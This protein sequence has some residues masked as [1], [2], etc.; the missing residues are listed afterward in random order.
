MLAVIRLCTF[1]LVS[2]ELVRHCYCFDLIKTLASF[3]K[4]HDNKEQI[5]DAPSNHRV[6][7]SNSKC[8]VCHKGRV[9]LK[10]SCNAL[11]AHLA[12][13]D[14]QGTCEDSE[15][16]DPCDPSPCGSNA[17]CLAEQESFACFCDPGF[18]GDP[19]LGC[20]ALPD[21]FITGIEPNTFNAVT[22][23][24]CF[25]IVNDEFNT[26]IS[27]LDVSLNGASVLAEQLDI[28]PGEICLVDV[29][30]STAIANQL[31]ISAQAASS[32]TILNASESFWVGSGSATISVVDPNGA[33]VQQDVTVVA[34]LADDTTVQEQKIGSVGTFVFGNLPARTIIFDAVAA[35]GSVGAAGLIGGGSAIITLVPFAEPSNIENNDFSEGT[36]GWKLDNAGAAFIVDHLEEVGPE[37]SVRML[38]GRRTQ[39]DLVN[40]DF[41]LPTQAIEGPTS[42]SR[43]FVTKEGT[44]G[45]RIRYRF[46][47]SEYPVYYGTEFNDFYRV[48]IRSES[49]G[50]SKIDVKAMN[51]LSPSDFGPGSIY[52]ST[53]WKELVLP[54]SADGDTIQV[55]VIV[56]NVGDGAFQSYVYIDF[57]EE[58]TQGLCIY[59]NAPPSASLT[60]GHAAIVYYIKEEATVTLTTYGLW[61]DAHPNTVDNGDATDI[62]TSFPGDDVSGY[63]YIYCEPISDKKKQM[64]DDLVGVNVEWTCT[65]SCASF[66]SETFRGVTGTDVDADD[67]LGIETPREISESILALNGGTLTPKEGLPWQGGIRRLRNLQDT[68]FPTNFLSQCNYI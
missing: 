18:S 11:E 28:S 61:P 45:V 42:T 8:S 56:A 37:F 68:S 26:D 51:D 39:D 10:I 38:R 54:V 44:T 64:L 35:D 4:G 41:T 50:G 9:T 67:F 7:M 13:G 29:S 17:F 66:A 1:V 19:L 3:D 48:S 46:E 59:S 34:R 36:D 14:F 5:E 52:P 12:H 21:V 55:D 30:L 60:A 40:K 32:G 49:A 25:A 24:I 27:T 47:T 15:I 22:S 43:T 6:L 20:N 53:A 62:R 57:V 23:T 31:S 2:L 16:T 65:N 33:V 63:G 58:L